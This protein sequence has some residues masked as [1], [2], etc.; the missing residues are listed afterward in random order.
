MMNAKRPI[1]PTLL[2]ALL[3][4]I[5]LLAS[6]SSSSPAES[7]KNAGE[8]AGTATSG[9]SGSETTIAVPMLV[10]VPV[11]VQSD[12][13]FFKGCWVRLIDRDAMPGKGN[14]VLT[15]VGNMNMP[16]FT[17]PSGVRWAGKA[18][19]LTVGPGAKVTVYSDPDY[20]GSSATLKPGQEIKDVRKE[21]GFVRPV[22]S[23]KVACTS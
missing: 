18:D 6:A 13:T 15:L 17:T 2:G 22:D 7:G 4:S 20:K 23:A 16:N 9:A 11:E 8:K 1:I 12:P 14:D 19:R 5:S 21:L 3:A 10:L